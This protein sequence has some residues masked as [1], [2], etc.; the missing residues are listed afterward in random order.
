MIFIG[1]GRVPRREER[2]RTQKQLLK[3]KVSGIR[4]AQWTRLFRDFEATTDGARL[5]ARMNEIRLWDKAANDLQVEYLEKFLAFA[6]QGGA[7]RTVLAEI[8]KALREFR[9]EKY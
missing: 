1:I 7:Y 9:A 4:T 5:R 3:G 6:K 2:R 8:E